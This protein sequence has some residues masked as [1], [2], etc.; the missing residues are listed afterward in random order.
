[1]SLSIRKVFLIILGAVA[2][3]PVASAQT[4]NNEI[5]NTLS[6]AVPFLRIA[7]DARSGAMGDLGVATLPSSIDGDRGWADANGW[8]FNPAKMAFMGQNM[9]FSVTYTPWLKQLVN[10]IYLASLYGF[11]RIDENQTVGGSLRYFSLGDIQFTDANG[12]FLQNY[13]PNEFAVDAGY[14]R[15]LSEVFSTGVMIRFI[16]S[17]LAKGMQVNNTPIQAGTSAAADVSFYYTNDEIK[18]SGNDAE[19]NFGLNISNLGAK[20]TYTEDAENKDFLPSNLGFGGAL[21]I[22]LDDHNEF[23]FGADINKLLVPTPDPLGAYRNKSVASGV[24]G[25]FSDAPFEEEMRELMYS[26]GVEYWYD[27]QFAIRGGYFSEHK[28]KGGRKFATVG[29]GLKYSVFGLNFSYLIPTNAQRNPLDN[30][31]RF[32]LLFDFEALKKDNNSTN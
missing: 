32:S 16:Y 4:S 30:T 3:M 1:M 22:H 23:M 27:K 6:T 31:L 15:K 21:N 12:T 25:S 28:T 18:I 14:A 9:G 8:F 7:P 26:V 13:S 5:V 20:I 24:L 29:L 19:L 11:K 2:I 17:N 10:D